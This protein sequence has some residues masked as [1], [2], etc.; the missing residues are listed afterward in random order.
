VTFL[1]GHPVYESQIEEQEMLQLLKGKLITH[2]AGYILLSYVHVTSLFVKR[3]GHHT[4]LLTI[5]GLIILNPRLIQNIRKAT[6]KQKCHSE[7]QNAYKTAISVDEPRARRLSREDVT[8][9]ARPFTQEDCA[10]MRPPR[11]N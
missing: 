9:T 6:K 3:S 2:L 4:T 5:N 1:L 11:N 10:G 7:R 8:A